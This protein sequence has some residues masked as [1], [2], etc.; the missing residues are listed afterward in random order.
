VP[1]GIRG[2]PGTYIRVF[3]V[4]EAKKGIGLARDEL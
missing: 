2:S 1:T 3:I 4:T